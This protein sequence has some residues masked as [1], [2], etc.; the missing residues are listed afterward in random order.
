MSPGLR[1][2]YGVASDR[3]DM[4]EV[5][6]QRRRAFWFSCH[7]DRSGGISYSSL[8]ASAPA[9]PVHRSGLI[10]RQFGIQLLMTC[11]F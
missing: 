11:A 2:G 4:T 6:V 5:A 9:R 7:S 10:K 8:R 3:L 1:Q